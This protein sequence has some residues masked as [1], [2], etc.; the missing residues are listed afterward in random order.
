M[1]NETSYQFG[2]QPSAIRELFAYGQARKAQIGQDKVYDYSL[3]NPSVPSPPL[4]SATLKELA[5][6]PAQQLHGYTAAQGL[7]STRT[8]IANNL[9]KRFGTS[10]SADN[11]YMTM[12]AAASLDASIGAITNRGDEVIVIAPYFPEYATWIAHAGAKCVEVLARESDF[13]IDVD[14]VEK[15]ITPKTSAVIINTPNNPVGVVYSCQNLCDFAQMLERKSKELGHSIFIISDEPYREIF[16]DSSNEPSWIP[17]IYAN[18]LVCYSWSKSLSMP[19]ER[20]GY[21]LVPDSVEDSKRVYAAVCGAGRALGYVCAPALFQM[22]IERCVDE[23]VNV[24][25]YCKNR[26]LLCEILDEIG[27]EYIDPQ[28]AFYLWMKSLEPDAQ[29]FSDKAKTHE[30][31]LVPSDSF[32]CKGWVRLGYCVSSDVISNSKDALRALMADYK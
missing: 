25:A 1:I 9:N 12:G 15:A 22:V 18:T 10:Y 6:L 14:A 23:P 20:I 5:D 19:G 30:L 2:A 29:A 31:L 17:D 7:A 16:F 26:E 27:F 8:A 11:L 32:G 21:V 13:Q 3:G 24:E 4:V 28:G